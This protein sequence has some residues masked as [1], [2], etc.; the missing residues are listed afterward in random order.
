MTSKKKKQTSFLGDKKVALVHDFL[1]YWGGAEA[2]L[3]VLAKMFPQAPIYTLL[4]DE[5]FTKKH[6]RGREIRTSFL[7][8]IPRWIRKK[9]TRLLPLMPTAI[10][11]LNLR[12]YDLVISSSSAFA[13]GI[14]V[15]PKTTHVCYMHA[16]M[17]YVWD[18][19]HQYFQERFGNRAKIFTRTF[20]NYL[21]TWDRA[22]ADRADH[23]V[24]NSRYTARRIEKYYRRESMVIYP[25]VE[26]EKFALSPDKANSSISSSSDLIEKQ[27]QARRG[28]YFLTTGRLATYKRVDL[29]IEAF[30]KLKLPLV[31]VGDGPERKKLEKLAQ[32]NSKIKILG[33]QSEE[34]LIR[35]YQNSRA[36][37]CATEDDFNITCVEA[38]AAG[39]PV[40]A[41][42]KGGVQETVIEGQTGIFFQE[43]RLELVVDGVRRFI[44]KE[45]D[46]DSEVIQARAREF[47]RERFEKEMRKYLTSIF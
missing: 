40:I 41:L 30:Q 8:K 9:H 16:P 20:L 19:Y 5:Q 28:S 44:E 45:A 18:Y 39:T 10:E 35:L 2:T 31:I 23:L 46:F 47:S 13:K 6:F 22:S 15:K 12:D 38:M 14:V 34:K 1:L 7:Q 42:K 29:L 26:V 4:Q 43:A 37:V 21:R 33:W 25:P 3:Q 24:A 32:G 17:R 36:F 11:S 27:N